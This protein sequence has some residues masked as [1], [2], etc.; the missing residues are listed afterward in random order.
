M[1]SDNGQGLR[2]GLQEGLLVGVAR[3]TS[4][5]YPVSIGAREDESTHIKFSVI[6]P[7]I[8]G[9]FFLPLQRY[10]HCSL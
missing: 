7:K 6:K 4:H 5:P 2:V 10:S 8:D 1:M 9:R 3:G